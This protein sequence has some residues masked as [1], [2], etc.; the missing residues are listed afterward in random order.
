M[1]R[2]NFNVRPI[3]RE[4]KRRHPGPKRAKPLPG[5][6]PKRRIPAGGASAVAW[7]LENAAPP[8]MPTTS[9]RD[10]TDTDL[11]LP[12]DD[13]AQEKAERFLRAAH[14]YQL[15]QEA[16]AAENARKAAPVH[17]EIEDDSLF[18]AHKVDRD[19]FRQLQRIAS[20]P[21]RSSKPNAAA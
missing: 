13:I 7:A 3:T 16:K 21:A 1:M 10:I 17:V 9:F 8:T 15:H 19:I 6:R 5:F 11:G 20:R 14:A 18:L 12:H 4:E 2:S